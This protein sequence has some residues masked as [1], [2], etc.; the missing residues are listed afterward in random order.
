M[1]TSAASG[2]TL[3]EASRRASVLIWNVGK[4]LWIISNG[5]DL[6]IPR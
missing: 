4:V 5:F 6:L 3:D 1:P 2:G